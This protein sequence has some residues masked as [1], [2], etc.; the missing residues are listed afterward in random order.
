MR[1]FCHRGTEARRR[2]QPKCVPDFIPET[3]GQDGIWFSRRIER[4][5]AMPRLEFIIS[6]R[7]AGVQGM[8]RAVAYLKKLILIMNGLRKIWEK[9]IDDCWL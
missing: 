7:G 6:G 3:K 9:T 5:L 8:R 4:S 2:G 1:K